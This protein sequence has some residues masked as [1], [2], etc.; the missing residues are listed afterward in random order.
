MF[1]IRDHGGIFGGGGKYRKGSLI[2]LS[3]LGINK[4]LEEKFM[5]YYYRPSSY[6]RLYN[7]YYNKQS[8]KIYMFFNTSDL[9]SNI[10][11]VT[12][13]TN[14]GTTT[15]DK[16][17]SHGQTG[18]REYQIVDLYP[19]DLTKNLFVVCYDR[20]YIVKRDLTQIATNTFSNS[21][22]YVFMTYFNGWLVMV[23]A[24]SAYVYTVR[25]SDYQ[26]SNT[27]PQISYST[28][29]MYPF[30][31]GYI[32]TVEYQ[33]NATFALIKKLKLSNDTSTTSLIASNTISDVNA[34]NDLT[35]GSK[36]IVGKRIGGFLYIVSGLNKIVKINDN[37][38]S[39]VSNIVFSEPIKNTE[40]NGN[41]LY[42]YTT[43]TVNY[44]DNNNK[45]Y[46]ID[47]STFSITEQF[48]VD[49]I[50]K[51]QILEQNTEL[52]INNSQIT[53]RYSGL[54]IGG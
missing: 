36:T 27:Y 29:W 34:R 16:I 17:I 11:W 28:Q 38:L 43:E 24:D 51:T 12:D 42:V 44:N 40:I 1:D 35:G 50:S 31:D 25:L 5:S 2:P 21:N 45:R 23:N 49:T 9:S 6:T 52:T 8:N 4:L 37:N 13:V 39:V 48:I 46:T 26:P 14:T 53:K 7:F 15:Q 18:L 32:F 20:W 47:L 54:K 3:D 19:T 10:I 33:Y 22:S 41:K 30:S